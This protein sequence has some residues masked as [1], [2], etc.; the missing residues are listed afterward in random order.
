[1]TGVRSVLQ[2]LVDTA[3]GSLVQAKYRCPCCGEI[4]E[5]PRH[6]GGDADLV[7][8]FAFMTNNAV[9]LVSSLVI[10]LLCLTILPLIP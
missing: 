5:Q 6:C 1:M 2:T 8:G 7:S 3:L 10:T 4:T 9:N